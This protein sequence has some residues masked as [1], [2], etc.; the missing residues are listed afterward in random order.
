MQ[1]I[2]RPKVTQYNIIARLFEL[3]RNARREALCDVSNIVTIDLQTGFIAKSI[4]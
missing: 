1:V 3:S 2:S 4:R